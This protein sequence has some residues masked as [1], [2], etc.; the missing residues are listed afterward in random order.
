MR[1]AT[2]AHPT[3]LHLAHHDAPKASV[4]QT[5]IFQR[6]QFTFNRRFIETKFAAFFGVVRRDADKDMQLVVKAA[7]GN[8]VATR[9]SRITANEMHLEVHH[10]AASQEVAVNFQEIQE[11]Q[12][13]HKDAK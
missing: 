13:K 11:M 5:Q 7:R 10:G 8:Y 9:I 12:I 6:G 2:A 4:P 3:A 1:D